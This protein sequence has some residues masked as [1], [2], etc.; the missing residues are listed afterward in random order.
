MRDW[1]KT[2]W[3][4]SVNMGVFRSWYKGAKNDNIGIIWF[5]SS[6]KSYLQL[7]STWWSLIQKPNELSWH[8]SVSLR[9]LDSGSIDLGE[10][11]ES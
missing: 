3:L 5:H 10:L 8:V 7:D 4:V 1:K 11:S 6:K 2:L 9:L